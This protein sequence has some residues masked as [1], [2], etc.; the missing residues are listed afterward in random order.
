M[1]I[2]ENCILCGECFT[3][4]HWIDADDDTALTWINEII[5]GKNSDVLYKCVT[6]YSCNE[7]CP[8]QANPYDRIAELQDKYRTLLPEDRVDALERQFTFNGE[9]APTPRERRIMSGCI[10][11]RTH[12][13]LMQGQLYDMPQVGGKP[14][15]CW[16]MLGHAGAQSVQKKHAQDFV[17]RLAATG[18]KEIVCFHDDCYTM[19]AREAPEFGV[20]V[21]F[22]PVHLAQYLVEY[23][24]DNQDKVTPLNI[25]VAYQRPCASKLTPEKEPFIDRLFGL[26]GVNRVQ[27]RY[28]RENGMCCGGAAFMLDIG[29][30]S[31]NRQKNLDDALS[32]GAK[33]MVCLCP[34]CIEQ[35]TPDAQKKNLP[36]IFIS[37]IARMALGEI[38]MPF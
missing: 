33:A 22:K 38:E 16:V 35:L 25:D 26:I 21:P 5:D 7:R 31:T 3:G 4:C 30:P 27:R 2:V 36:L 11:N 9:L 17:N 8:Q 6:C 32:H 1:F 12:T 10:F 18:A 13:H 19:L 14:Y 34:M 29:D 23:L 20:N 15:F 37:D 28:D 24:E